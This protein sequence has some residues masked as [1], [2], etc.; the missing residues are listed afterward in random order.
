MTRPD[1]DGTKAIAS[2][3][4]VSIR[5]VWR[6]TRGPDPL[7]LLRRRG[8]IVARRRDVEAWLARQYQAVTAPEPSTERPRRRVVG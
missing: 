5:T 4:G 6:W 2:Y 3:L 1:L 8:A 7:P